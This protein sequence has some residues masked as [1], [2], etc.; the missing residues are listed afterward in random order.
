MK[1][2]LACNLKLPLNNFCKIKK[3]NRPYSYCKLCVNAKSRNYY[4][5]NGGKL[6]QKNKKLKFKIN[7]TNKYIWIRA[8]LRAKRLNINFNLQES[9]VV[10]PFTCPIFGI[11]LKVNEIKRDINSPSIDRI[12]NTL[13]YIKGNILIVSWKANHIKNDATLNEMNLILKNFNKNEKLTVFDIFDINQ[14]DVFN[15]IFWLFHAAKHRAKNKSLYFNLTKKDIIIPL[16]CPLLNIPITWCE[17][18][19]DNSPTLDRVDNDKGYTADN[20]RVISLRANRLKSIATYNEY[21]CLYD[22]YTN[23]VTTLCNQV[24]I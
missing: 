19:T 10:I 8:K 2:C 22:F 12:N 24:L 4:H 9:D 20:I 15:K 1:L 23:L 5:N 6:Q 7:E 13:G 11:E 21:K 3:S 17:K 14:K 16:I 18:L